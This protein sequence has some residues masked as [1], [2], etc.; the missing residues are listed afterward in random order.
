MITTTRSRALGHRALLIAAFAAAGLISSL[1]CILIS[2]KRCL[3]SWKIL[4]GTTRS[5]DA[6]ASPTTSCATASR[7]THSC[8]GNFVEALAQFGLD[9][10]YIVSNVNFFLSVPVAADGAAVNV[11]GHSAAANYVDLRAERDVLVVISNCPKLYNPCNGW[12]PTPVR[13]IEWRPKS[14][15]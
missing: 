14:E 4:A 9:R 10:R 5:T 8:F 13:I 15:S 7:G 12:N 6:V 2:A 3:R 11:Y 1:A